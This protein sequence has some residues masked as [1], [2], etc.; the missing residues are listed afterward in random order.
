MGSAKVRIDTLPELLEDE[1]APPFWVALRMEGAE[2]PDDEDEDYG[3]VQVACKLVYLPAYD[4]SEDRPFFEGDE[5]EDRPPNELR[6]AVCRCRDLK[7]ADSA[8]SLPFKR[9]AA[10][11][12]PYITLTLDTGGHKQKTRTVKKTLDPVYNKVFSFE[13]EGQL[14]A[15]QKP[16]A[17]QVLICEAYDWDLVGSDDFLGR[18][19]LPFFGLAQR[20]GEIKRTWINFA[21][22]EGYVPFGEEE[23]LGA[24]LLVAQCRYNPALAFEPFDP[25]ADKAAGGAGRLGA[26]R[27][28]PFE[29][30]RRPS[31]TSRP[32]NS[33]WPSSA[34]GAC[35]PRPSARV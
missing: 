31:R 19:R 8:V 13:I 22:E 21:D 32:T 7:A 3:E 28:D 33:M 9:S 17:P 5:I 20:P 6:I 4:P 25:E 1:S 29:Q 16:G 35:R 12:D 14:V 34:R 26:R 30:A 23:T 15:E 24:I 27:G 10:S 11:S 2:D 18:V